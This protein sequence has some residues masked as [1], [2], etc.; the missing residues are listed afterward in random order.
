MTEKVEAELVPGADGS[1][2]EKLLEAGRYLFLRQEFHRVSIRRIAERAGVNSAMIAYYFGDKRGLFQAVVMSYV[3][4][5]KG[6]L[7][8]GLQQ[9]PRRSFGDVFRFYFRHAPRELI[10]IVIKSLLYDPGDHGRWLTDEILRPLLREVERQLD[11]TLPAGKEHQPEFARLMIQSLLI[12]PVLM[13]PALEDLSRHPMDEAY[14]DELADYIGMMLD[15][16]FE[17]E[18]PQ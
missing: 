16:A 1:A 8:E 17:L 12:F 13:K 6:Y 2:R 15:R 14:Y 3:L 5:V 9:M 10:Q 7:L 11:Q 4:P 18:K